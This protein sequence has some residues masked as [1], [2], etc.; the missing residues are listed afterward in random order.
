MQ[1][2]VSEYIYTIENEIIFHCN[3]II[4]LIQERILPNI[5]EPHEN[6]F[7]LKLV[8]DYHR[9]MAEVVADD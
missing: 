2:V 7:Y 9:Y 4:S 8:G 6:V 1:V 3:T 5:Q